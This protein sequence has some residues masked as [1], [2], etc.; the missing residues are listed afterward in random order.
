M[1][2]GEP[3]PN[4]DDPTKSPGDGWEWRP[5]TGKP[6]DGKG[7]WHNPGT[8]ESLHPDLDHP[9]PIGGH[10]DYIDPAGK[11]WRVYP[12]GRREPK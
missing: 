10:Y 5:P 1:D 7:A 6:G 12:D 9:A 2:S 4:F 8:G 3:G 11:K